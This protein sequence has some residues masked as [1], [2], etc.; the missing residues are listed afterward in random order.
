MF[1]Y[2]RDK[3][4]SEYAFSQLDDSKISPELFNLTPRNIKNKTLKKRQL[5]KR[6]MQPNKLKTELLEETCRKA[7]YPVEIRMQSGYDH[8]YYFIAS[9]MRQHIAFHAEYLND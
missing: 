1:T 7:K 5:V 6:D 3:L 4:K 9:F 8:S 2:Y